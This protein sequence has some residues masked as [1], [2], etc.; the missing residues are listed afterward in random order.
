MATAALC[1]AVLATARPAAA[2]HSS[3]SVDGDALDPSQWRRSEFAERTLADGTLER[4]TTVAFRGTV[5]TIDERLFATPPATETLLRFRQTSGTSARL[6]EINTLDIAV[7]VPDGAHA[8]LHGFAGSAESS[9]DYSEN[10]LKLLPG[11]A[12]AVRVPVGGRSSNGIL[13][14]F[15][16]HFNGTSGAGS[17]VV[18]SVGWSGSWR[19]SVGRSADGKSVRVQA[20]L[21]LFNAS[22]QSGRSFRGARI[23]CANYTGDV[24]SGWNVHRHALARHFLQKDGAGRVRGGLVSAWTA[25]TYHNNVNEAN[26][27]AMVKGVKAAAVEAA[28]IDF[29]WYIG[30]GL[31]DVGNWVRPPQRSV[32]ATKFPHGLAAVAKAAHAGAESSRTKFI[33]WTEPE[34]TAASAYLGPLPWSYGSPPTVHQRNVSAENFTI[35]SRTHKPA[36]SLLVDL[37]NPE[38]LRYM[39]AYLSEAVKT[40][41]LDVLRMD[42]NI[43]PAASWALKDT[44]QARAREAVATAGAAAAV[45]DVGLSEAAHVEG[46]YSMWRSVIQEN[47]GVLLDNCASGGR[48]IDLETAMLS[49]PLWQSD[50]AGNRGDTSESWQSQTMGL[51]C[52]LPVHSGGCP[53]FDSHTTS[54]PTG[55]PGLTTAV[56]PYVWRSCGTVG[57]A[58]AW[59]PAMWAELAAGSSNASGSNSSLA[60]GVRTAVAETQRMRALVAEVGSDYYPLTPISPSVPWAAYEHIASNGSTGFALVFRRPMNMSGGGHASSQRTLRLVTN[61]SRF[62]WV[63][64]APAGSGYYAG[65]YYFTPGSKASATLE[66]CQ[67]VCSSD[68]EKCEGFTFVPNGDPPCALYSAIVG[69]FRATRTNVTQ[70]AKRYDC[71]LVGGCA[72]GLNTGVQPAVRHP[73]PLNCAKFVPNCGS[74]EECNVLGAATDGQSGCPP[75]H[76]TPHHGGGNASTAEFT[77]KLRGLLPSASYGVSYYHD[78][79]EQTAS[80]VLK[81]NEL[82]QLNVTMPARSVLLLWFSA[83]EDDAR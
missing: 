30:G 63:H 61:R 56:E 7:P 78:S 41:E 81:G 62:T 59:T 74:A 10:E 13:P 21:A 52:F 64:T 4:N 9:M 33:V 28:W 26:M 80:Q 50:L 53:R 57:K 77:L 31:G 44:Q 35:H 22:L 67:A 37:G 39:T 6:S 46:L 15:A 2:F 71:G 18:L 5:A 40:F 51:S 65:T 20:G 19:V 54:G 43:D 75:Y 70:L 32:D 73:L 36:T 45:V 27:L 12:P 34:R 14:L 82:A 25:Q 3:W 66:A 38:V 8:T 58:I 24:L 72:F 1:C 76:D 42:F 69:P 49:T 11:A 17:G 29:G 60:R 47:P 68:S 55:E 23:L 79:Y 16:I 48:R 83:R